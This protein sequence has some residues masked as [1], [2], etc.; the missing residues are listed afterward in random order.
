MEENLKLCTPEE[1]YAHI[2]E[3]LEQIATKILWSVLSVM[4][5]ESFFRNNK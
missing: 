3:G 5:K 4:D 2:A 1:A